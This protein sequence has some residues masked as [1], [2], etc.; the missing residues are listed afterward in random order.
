MSGARDRGPVVELRLARLDDAEATRRMQ[1]VYE[2][3]ILPELVAR[4]IA[5]VREAGVVDAAEIVRARSSHRVELVREHR[6]G[7]RCVLHREGASEATA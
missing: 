6:R 3:P 2:A 1:E 5:E 4:R 7:R